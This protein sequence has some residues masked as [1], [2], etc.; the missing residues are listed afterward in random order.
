MNLRKLLTVG[1][2]VATVLALVACGTEEDGGSIYG[3]KDPADQGFGDGDQSGSLGGGGSSGT[4]P[5]EEEKA[6]VTSSAKAEA[7]PVFLAF[8]YDRSGSMAGNKWSSSKAAT[9]AFF[10]SPDSAGLS[11]SLTFFPKPGD[12]S[13]CSDSDYESPQVPMTLL[14]SPTLGDR[15]D[16][17]SPG[18]GTPTRPALA[19]AIDYA[20]GLML[21]KAKDG[22][23]AIVLVTDGL[24][25]GCSNNTVQSVKQLAATVAAKIPTYVIGVGNALQNLDEIAVGGGTTKAFLVPDNNPSQIQADFKKAVDAIKVSAIACEYK[26]PTPPNGEKLDPTKVNV[27]YKPEGGAAQ[28]MKYNKD[29][30]GGTGWRYDNEANPTQ[31]MMCDASCDSIKSKAGTVD[32]QF[33]CATQVAGVN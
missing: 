16:R 12:E 22:K 23:V 9:K 31:I 21:A 15:L 1:F 28:P 27:A 6:C 19:G 3:D 20:E 11:A 18:G 4:A 5:K 29:C 14:P 13:A 2:S 24:P 8:V 7:K 26:V 33:G 17:E 32:V 25:G 10:T 30:A